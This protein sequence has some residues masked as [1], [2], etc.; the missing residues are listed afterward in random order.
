MKL[1]VV[2]SSYNSDAVLR[3]CLAALLGQGLAPGA[4]AR[5]GVLL[6]ALCAERFTRGRDPAGLVAGDLIDRLPLVMRQLRHAD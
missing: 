5:S 4:A 2:V 3:R 1:P 6:H